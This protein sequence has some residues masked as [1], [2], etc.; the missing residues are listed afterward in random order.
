MRM[1]QAKPWEIADNLAKEYNKKV[2]AASDGMMFNL[3]N[4]FY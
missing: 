4:L 1:L 2:I 3:E